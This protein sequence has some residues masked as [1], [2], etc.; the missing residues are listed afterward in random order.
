MKLTKYVHACVVLED[1]GTTIV[2]DPG[3]FATNA[4]ELLSTADAVLI[5]HDHF[6][7]LDIEAVKEIVAQRPE[8]PV[9]APASV[10]EQIGAGHL[11]EATDGL[12]FSV[13][14]VPVQ[15]FLTGHAKIHPDMTMPDNAAYLIGGSVYH[16]GDTYLVPGVAVDT[17][18]VPTSGPWTKLGEAVDFVRAVNPRQALQIHE[19]MLSEIGQQS[20]AHFLGEKGL[21]KTPFT[22]LPVGESIEIA[23]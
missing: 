5:T 10:I 8:L 12:T 21:T 17:L 6:D 9:Y 14:P 19:A 4:R 23:G 2:V 7:H 15:V 16:P 20:T 1:Q 3:T 22:L 13:G 18:L 11:T